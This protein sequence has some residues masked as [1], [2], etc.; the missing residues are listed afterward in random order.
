MP[1]GRFA[2]YTA[3]GSALWNSVLIGL[4]WVL[5]DRWEDVS[6]YGQFLE[7]GALAL[8]IGVIG[9]F[10]WHRQNQSRAS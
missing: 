7:Y 1:L 2:L 4:G 9:R 3:I 5:G 6:R 8:V 10:V